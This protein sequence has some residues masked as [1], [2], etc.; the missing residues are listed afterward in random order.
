MRFHC[1][2]RSICRP[3]S[4]TGVKHC[5]LVHD[6]HQLAGVR[7][8]STMSYLTQMVGLAY[9]QLLVGGGGHGAGDRVYPRN[10]A[11][12]VED[13]GQLLGRPDARHAVGAGADLR[14]CM[15]W[16]WCRRE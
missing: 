5:G 7:A 6:Q 3:W 9:A 11:A 8:G 14:W 12:R 16:C 10:R 1:G 13:A 2:T 15:R 4:R